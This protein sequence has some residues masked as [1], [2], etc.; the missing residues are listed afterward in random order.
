MGPS[1]DHL[2]AILGHL[3][4]ILTI[5]GHL[6]AILGPS[7][8]YVGVILGIWSHLGGIL[9]HLRAILEPK[10]VPGPG[11]GAKLL[12]SAAILEDFGAHFGDHFGDVFFYFSS[13]FRLLFGQI[14]G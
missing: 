6:G 13:N 1:W 7:W 14:F 3:K 8:G 9:G 5:L 2:G 10:R 11:D 12:A 4:A